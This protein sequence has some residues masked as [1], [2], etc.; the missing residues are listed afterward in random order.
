MKRILCLLCV[1]A[2]AGG[3]LAAC[4][5]SAPPPPGNGESPTGG[6][7]ETEPSPGGDTPVD[8]AD[9]LN[10]LGEELGQAFSATWPENEYTKQVPKPKFDVGLGTA[11]EDSYVVLCG[12]T[13]PELRDYVKDLQKAGFSKGADTTDTSA[14]GLT[15]YSYTA[16][17]GKGY[18][19]EIGNAMGVSTISITKAP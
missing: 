11:T 4:G 1:L 9:A 7:G 8:I 19:V 14:F 3:L 6:G 10:K 15:V 5:K 18:R 12:A 17:N 2:L 16:H 13:I